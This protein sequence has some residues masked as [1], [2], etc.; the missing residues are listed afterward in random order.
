[1]ISVVSHFLTSNIM[2]D[3]GVRHEG[4]VT[5]ERTLTLKCTDQWRSLVE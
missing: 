1:M 4:P 3:T 5:A 2:Q